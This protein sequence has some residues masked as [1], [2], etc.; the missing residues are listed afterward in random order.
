MSDSN[1]PANPETSGTDAS[2]A[3]DQGSA[4][5]PDLARTEKLSAGGQP[6]TPDVSQT[7]SELSSMS[8]TM[9]PVSVSQTLAQTFVS[10]TQVKRAVDLSNCQLGEF[11]LLRRLGAG[12]MAQVY[13]AEQTSLKR[14]VAIKIMRPD[15][16]DQDTYRKRFEQEA[17]AAAGL[18]H[19]NIVQVYAVGEADG[20]QYIAQEYVHGLNL[21]EYLK[22]RKPPSAHLAIHLMK[23]VS[24]ALYAAHQAGIVHRDIKPEN[25]MVTRKMVAKVTDFGLAQLTQGG[26]R[27]NL[28][29]MGVTMGTPLY[30]SPE[31]INDASVDLRSDLYSLGVTFY[32]LLAGEP[33][34][35]ARTAVALAYKHLN[36][37]PQPLSNSRPDLP[38][39]LIELIHRLMSKDPAKR[40][41][42]ARLVQTE[43]KRIEKSGELSHS[44]SASQ[45][46]EEQSEVSPWWHI[47]KPT[48]KKFGIACIIVF[49]LAASAGRERRRGNPL[50]T[51]VK[52]VSTVKELG[53]AQAQLRHAE[54]LW[55]DPGIS[56]ETKAEAWQAVLDFYPD[57][58][59]PGYEAKLGLATL[60]LIQKRN[61]DQAEI[62]FRELTTQNS[63]KL[64]ANGLA[65]RAI[66]TA[67]RGEHDKAYETIRVELSTMTQHL[68]PDMQKLIR[69]AIKEI[70]RRREVPDL[71]LQNLFNDPQE[72]P[73]PA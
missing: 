27:V 63:N 10:G 7:Q 2:A 25:I 18:N 44:W 23:H 1:L 62:W 55:R 28:T 34:F 41:D 52:N 59:G 20:L 64:K 22:K 13:L 9:A 6:A 69:Y 49:L 45:E 39:S 57:A 65:G 38:P 46:A 53:S 50:D 3:K 24:A 17:T 30:M 19:Q 32:H 11:R 14:N 47:S 48:L 70:N 31:Q 5:Q 15:F 66:I 71:D 16:G 8:G 12:G 60:Y 68:T 40:F 4:P 61:L 35:R 29:Q 37:E 67:V 72:S 51:P 26:E 33:P 36:E 54:V 56:I 42:S 58:S 21:V 73:P 43:L